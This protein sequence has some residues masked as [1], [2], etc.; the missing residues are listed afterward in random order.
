MTIL[1]VNVGA[2]AEN[3]ADALALVAVQVESGLSCQAPG[4]AMM[5]FC[6]ESMNDV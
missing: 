1:N 4:E 3:R 5:M 6:I 2:A